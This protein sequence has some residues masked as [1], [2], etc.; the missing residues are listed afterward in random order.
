VNISSATRV[1]MMLK[2]VVHTLLAL[3]AF[4]AN[5]VLCRMALGDH[6]IDASSFTVIRLF[7]GM[8]VLLLICWFSRDK[9]VTDR[10]LNNAP[11]RG[12]W[13]SALMLFIY[14]A[15]FSFAYISLDTATGALVLF[16]AVQLTMIIMHVL[17]GNRLH[18][19]EWCGLSIAFSGFVYLIMPDLN[20][21]SMSGFILMMI[22]GIAWGFYTLRG[23]TSANPLADTTFNFARTTPFII[24]LALV[25]LPDLQLSTQGIILAVLSGAL[26]SG[27]GYTLWYSA[28]AGLSVTEAA[29]VQ[30][31]VPVL[32]AVGGLLFVSELISLRLI[33]SGVMILGG[34]LVV[35]LARHY[36][37][38]STLQV[39]A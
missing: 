28:L 6:V 20:T 3:I 25:F 35:V 5:S 10:K 7:S 21:P 34:I 2:T 37:T 22:A 33:I 19:S 38:T 13:L 24:I 9:K 36:F 4:A 17:S 27:I 15:A 29:V 18:I 23:K 8:I 12:S 30:L 26:A 14:A 39:D 31:S 32:A 1:D 16:A 11:G